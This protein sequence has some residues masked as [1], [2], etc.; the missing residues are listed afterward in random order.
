MKD[1]NINEL[2]DKQIQQAI[3]GYN[4]T[5]S[6]ACWDKLSAQLDLL[7]PQGHSMSTSSGHAWKAWA[8]KA[9]ATAAAVAGIITAILLLKPEHSAET[10]TSPDTAITTATIRDTLPETTAQPTP[11]TNTPATTKNTSATCI[12]AHNE[13]STLS[14]ASP[15]TITT[16]ES[17]SA[18]CLA[19]SL[20]NTSITPA[21]T[22]LSSPSHQADAKQDEPVIP[23]TPEHNYEE[24][25]I[26]ENHASHSLPDIFIPNIITPNS[27]GYN[28]CFEISGNDNTELNHLIVF[29]SGGKVI[30]SKE[31]YHNEWC[32]DN[33]ANGVYFYYFKYTFQ[34]EQYMRK[35][36]VTIKR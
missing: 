23:A 19:T 14:T 28:D 17:A 20:A 27:D 29:T 25:S 7:A 24:E 10:A 9:G 34:G 4:E 21:I 35:G 18:P 36:S 13:P 31:N 1:N 3:Q 26:K 8:V 22:T 2:L 15:V 30:F 32:P 33:I 5:P 16:P 6:N 12:V 11:V